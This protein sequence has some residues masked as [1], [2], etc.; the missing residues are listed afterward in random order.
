MA[1]KWVRWLL[2]SPTPRLEDH[3]SIWSIRARDASVFFILGALWLVALARIGY[4]AA[5]QPGASP[6]GWLNWVD[7][8][9][10]T[11]EEFGEVGIGM[12]MLAMLLTRPANMMGE[13]AMSIYQAMVNRYVIPVIEKHKAEGR[14]EGLEQGLERGLEQG[15]EQ[16]STEAHKAWTAWNQR[17]VDAQRLG[18]NFDEA[19]PRS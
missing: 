15:R 13:T 2:P 18:R 7:F 10:A 3:I 9:L 6:V 4:N 5:E 12:A 19:P 11:L 17:R 16:G 14:A 8:A 1:W